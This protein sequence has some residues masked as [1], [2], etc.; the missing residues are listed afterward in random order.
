MVEGWI[1]MIEPESA[2]KDAVE[3]LRKNGPEG[4]PPQ[5]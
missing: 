1:S 2:W 4:R 5:S 3:W